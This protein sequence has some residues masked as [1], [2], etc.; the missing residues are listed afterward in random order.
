MSKY[1]ECPKCHNTHAFA[2]RYKFKWSIVC[3]H[4]GLHT[5]SYNDIEAAEMNW[6]ILKKQIESEENNND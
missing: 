4:C 5:E 2:E 3:P 6:K 1:G